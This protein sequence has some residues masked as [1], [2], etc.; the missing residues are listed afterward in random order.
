MAFRGNLSEEKIQE[1]DK[2]IEPIADFYDAT[3][4]KV[5]TV[6]LSHMPE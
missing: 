6:F 3:R 5:S 2:A 1:V 4:A